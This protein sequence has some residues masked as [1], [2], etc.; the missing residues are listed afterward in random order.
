MGN[1]TN[2]AA[3]YRGAILGLKYARDNGYKNVSLQG[4]SQLVTNQVIILPHFSLFCSL[5]IIDVSKLAE[6]SMRT[7]MFVLLNLTDR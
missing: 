3:E 4:D 5:T 6:S 1:A 2:N 7:I